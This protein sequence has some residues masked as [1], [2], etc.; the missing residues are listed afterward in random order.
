M[1][2]VCGRWAVVPPPSRGLLQERQLRAVCRDAVPACAAELALPAL[3][4]VP[5]SLSPLLPS[6]CLL[7]SF[8]AS[9]LAQS[10]RWLTW[11]P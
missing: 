2:E 9:M 7:P 5:P 4:L 10:K 11:R 1:S 6:S 8:C 3:T